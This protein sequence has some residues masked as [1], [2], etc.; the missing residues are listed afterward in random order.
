MALCNTIR[1]VN[2]SFLIN[3][4]QAPIINTIINQSSL[5]QSNTNKMES[6]NTNLVDLSKKAND[7]DEQIKKLTEIKAQITIEQKNTE[8]FQSNNEHLTIP[9]QFYKANNI[10][11]FEKLLL[12]HGSNHKYDLDLI[13]NKALKEKNLV[14]CISLYIGNYL[15]LYSSDNNRP[16]HYK[17]IDLYNKILLLALE[18]ND[19][20]RLELLKNLNM[21]EL[22]RNQNG[23]LS[24][25]SLPKEINLSTYENDKYLE[26][27]TGI[28]DKKYSH[29]KSIAELKN[30]IDNQNNTVLTKLFNNMTIHNNLN[31]IEHILS[32]LRKFGEIKVNNEESS[33]ICKIILHYVNIQDEVVLYKLNS[34][35]PNRWHETCYIFINQLNIILI[36]NNSLS[37]FEK[38]YK[39][40][41]ISTDRYPT[42]YFKNNSTNGL[43]ILNK[44]NTEVI[45]FELFKAVYQK[46]YSVAN[47]ASH[48]EAILYFEE[49]SRTDILEFL[50][51]LPL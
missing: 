23:N 19:L 11:T 13:L 30:N 51:N 6:K 16:N 45:N 10:Y 18:L 33:T 37:W 50:I 2:T 9:M 3:K 8:L 1:S 32:E 34:Y 7:I 4:T 35:L 25:F 12:I 44:L 26:L 22:I 43:F 31:I 17:T 39:I 40:F 42:F 21:I 28:K 24:E 36:N 48:I 29:C 47:H 46:K 20:D 5:N 41:S 27:I 14:Y 15:N 49:T 38:V